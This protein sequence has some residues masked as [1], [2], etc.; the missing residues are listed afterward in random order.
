M[1]AD[2]CF[3]VKR[4]DHFMIPA[5]MFRTKGRPAHG[6][7]DFTPVVVNQAEPIVAIEDG[8]IIIADKNTGKGDTS[9]MDI[10]LLGKRTGIR[11]WYGHL[12]RVGVNV[13]LG[14]KRGQVI[15]ATGTTGS[16]AS[17]KASS[18][19]VHLHLEAH[20]PAINV[21]IDPWKWLHDA[22]D[23]DGSTMPLAPSREQARRDYSKASAPATPTPPP[24]EDDMYSNEDRARDQA[25]WEW[26]K[27][28]QPKV[29][30]IHAT[31][32]EA[33]A[34]LARIEEK[35]NGTAIDAGLAR[36][37]AV[38]GR[39]MVAGVQNALAE[40]P[41]TGAKK[42]DIDELNAVTDRV[43]ADL[44]ARLANPTA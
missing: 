33:T 43:A 26:L 42:L 28:V 8:F 7:I 25:T 13:G 38:E 35:L 27:D 29:A 12:S 15:G 36:W 34:T 2:L 40:L 23:V 39:R 14:V 16:S 6:G 5:A 18:T 17:G 11:W 20:Y 1:A 31:I 44:S 21:E 3:P 22:P 24:E 4:A 10:M 37:A 30:N 41:Q 19:G 32:H 9:G